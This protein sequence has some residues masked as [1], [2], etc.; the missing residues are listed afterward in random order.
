[1]GMTETA[2][3]RPAVG[4]QTVDDGRPRAW[5][6]G[7]RWWPPPTPGDR[8][9]YA[10]VL[11]ACAALVVWMANYRLAYASERAHFMGDESGWIAAA[12][13]YTDLALHGELSRDKWEAA[14]LRIF[15][16]I[17]PNLGKF[18]LGTGL[19]LHPG[20][21]PHDLEFRRLYNFDRGLAWNIE[22]G[23]VPQTDTV[24]RA[25]S[26]NRTFSVG[27]VV[28]LF[29]GLA[30]YSNPVVAF[31]AVYLVL[32]NDW[33]TTPL[34]WAL[35]DAYYNLFLFGFF[36]SLGLAIASASTRAMVWSCMWLGI[37]GGLACSV[38]VT[39][40][41]LTGFTVLAVLAL[42]FVMRRDTWRA[43]T[44]AVCVFGVTALVVV[45][46]LNPF[47]WPVDGAS[48]LLEFPKLYLRW[49]GALNTQQ[50]L[51]Q[52]WP[53]SHG[54]FWEIH[55]VL[56]AAF[57]RFPAEWVFFIAGVLYSAQRLVRA[58]RSRRADIAIV[59]LAYF[60]AN[61]IF[62]LA[63]LKLNFRRYYL[64][65]EFSVKM[66][67]AIGAFAAVWALVRVGRVAMQRIGVVDPAIV[68]SDA[69][70]SKAQAR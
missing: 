8:V 13:Y 11:L 67:T 36:A 22:H 41:P 34:S 9:F 3:D 53:S 66:L 69:A 70:E 25:R 60:L 55:R 38:K 30:Y 54:R 31:L 4:T 15:G 46:A 24:H 64:P 14:D 45:Y 23:R 35:T 19:R 27:C 48:R 57:A 10:L 18:I 42:R 17:N 49:I 5:V 33:F 59:P 28:L 43:Y 20:R 58:V 52:S 61:Y 44:L 2:N 50:D 32:T 63:F 21:E 29:L 47:F 56:F 6:D 62:L 1:M 65:A 39:G 40:L 51:V 12:G 37:L 68:S 26:V 16:G 7:I